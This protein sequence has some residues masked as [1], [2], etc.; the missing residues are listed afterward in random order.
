[1]ITILIYFSKSY[2]N[3]TSIESNNEADLN[4][5]P[6]IRAEIEILNGCGEAG[7]ANLF[8]RFLRSEGYDVIDIRNADNFKYKNTI[9]LFHKMDA[10]DKAK[11]LSQAYFFGLTNNLLTKEDSSLV[12]S[13]LQEVLPHQ[14]VTTSSGVIYGSSFFLRSLFISKTENDI[15]LKDYLKSIED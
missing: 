3:N 6:Y 10:E 2:L 8:T 11:E 7:A 12:S 9:V 1:M 13:Y 15:Y 4:H 5:S 14:N